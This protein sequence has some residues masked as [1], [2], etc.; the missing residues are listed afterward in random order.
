MQHMNSRERMIAAI[1]RREVDHVPLYA[2]V[3]GF[4]PPAHLRWSEAGQPV[5]F[6]YT[7]RM[8]HLHTLPQ[9]WDVTQDFKRV[10]AWL[11]LGIDDVLD[12]SVPWG[13]DERVTYLD[14]QM[15]PGAILASALNVPITREFPLMVR[16]YQTPEGALY[17]VIR[18]TPEIQPPGWVVQPPYVAL[19]EDFNLPRAIQHLINGP[20]DV[21]LVKWLYQRP[22]P[23]QETWL[24]ERMRQVAGFAHE[25]D[26]LIQAWSAYGVDAAVWMAGVENA[27]M[28]AMET[29]DAFDE[30]LD[31]IH[32]ADKGRTALAL[33]H[34]VDMVVERGWYSSI[35]FWSPRIFKRCFKPRIAELAAM[36]HAHGKLFGYV[37]TTGVKLLGPEL[38]DAGVDLLYFVDPAQ[39]GIDL[40]WARQ[41]FAGRMAVAGG[42]S[43]SLTLTQAD[44]AEI[45]IAVRTA[46]EVFGARGGFILSPVDALFPD[47]PWSA[48]QAMIDAWRG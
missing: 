11:S 3:F 13:Q 33:Q 24:A 4:R 7:Q 38:M 14:R 9:A 45:R 35:D 5:E 37:M 22:G 32:V 41:T 30:L 8:E 15:P 26:V 29:P 42:I 1:R 25:R 12:V 44:A 10:D 40:E 16:E 31:I 36:A 6:W 23:A 28:L 43:T 27:I 48:V 46:L 19:F 17:H 18:R 2:W 47:T 20:Q 21:P 39:D 34:D